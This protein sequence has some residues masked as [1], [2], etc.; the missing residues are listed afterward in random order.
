MEIEQA[1]PA[2]PSTLDRSLRMAVARERGVAAGQL[3]W[4]GTDPELFEVFY[5]EHVE[6]VQRFVARR[7]G[8][9][10]LAA[11]LTAEIFLA[12]IDS[13]DRYRPG[14]GTPKAWLYGIARALVAN[15]RRRRDRERA[16]EER[17]RGS[18]LLDDED[19]ARM[20]A[21]IDAAAQ[22]RSLYAAME[23]LPEAER[24]V[25]EL[26]ALDEM[27]VAEAPA[28]AGVRPVTARV[29]LH[30]ARRRLRAELDLAMAATTTR[31]GDG[32]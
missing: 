20:D 24:A 21:R 31:E 22:A 9:R 8:N 10:E 15:D 19:A 16:R 26:V 28:A 25:L 18:A 12:A 5:R 1:L 32:S 6:E 3:R 23:R 30:R 14:R 29:R 27:T 7:V 17:F 11:D 2:A 13:A 4:I